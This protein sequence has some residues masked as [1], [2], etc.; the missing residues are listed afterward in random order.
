[1]SD[2]PPVKIVVAADQ[3]ALDDGL[4]RAEDKLNEFGRKMNNVASSFDASAIL[5]KAFSGMEKAKA[6]I[7][8]MNVA[9]ELLRGNFTTAAE[10]VKTLPLGIG[11]T[12][13]A[14]ELL[15]GKW[16]GI[17]TEIEH[18][19]KL[20]EHQG[21]MVLM[22]AERSESMRSAMQKVGRDASDLADQNRIPLMFPESR[23][24]HEKLALD[25]KK[26]F[27]GID[28]AE[29]AAIK[30][31]RD[32]AARE[33]EE[34]RKTPVKAPNFGT[35]LVG[36]VMNWMFGDAARAAADASNKRTV[37]AET[38]RVAK[39]LDDDLA[40]IKSTASG[41]RKAETDAYENDEWMLRREDQKKKNLAI[42]KQ[43]E[44][45]RALMDRIDDQNKARRVQA[46]DDFVDARR[47]ALG[48][49]RDRMPTNERAPLIEAGMLTRSAV[50][51][52]RQQIAI[53][54]KELTRE[55]VRILKEIRDQRKDREGFLAGI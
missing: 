48:N 4:R 9:T 26:K 42:Q 36:V 14:L 15:L 19:T 23:Q 17:S 25:Y 10:V 45:D 11:E 1:M 55:T 21:K 43:A 5:I 33:M 53:D 2:V 31:R 22:V 49:L 46:L 54:Q 38:A 28:D 24:P 50:A 3:K 7:G 18:N 39:A 27:R 40:R 8:A 20:I 52:P 16:T 47:Q 12:A 35:G 37:A 29:E 34:A 32:Q 41:L 13:R 6:I 51:D 44:R 30:T